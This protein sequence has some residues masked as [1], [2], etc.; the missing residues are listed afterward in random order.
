ME[1]KK[2]TVGEMPK[3]ST[4]GLLNNGKLMCGYI[5]VGGKVCGFSG[6]CSLKVVAEIK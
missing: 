6:S 5:I 1:A 3:C 2:I 4:G